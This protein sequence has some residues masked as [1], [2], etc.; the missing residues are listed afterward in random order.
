M[1]RRGW[2]LVGLAAGAAL[3]GPKLLHRALHRARDAQAQANVEAF[4]LPSA[5]LY[6]LTSG[7]LFE[8]LFAQIAADLAATFPRGD[9]LELG[10]GPGRLA[11]RLARLAPEPRLTGVDISPDM[12]E[13]ASRRAA[14]AGLSDRVRFEVGDV[15]ALR[16]ADGRFDA[17]LATFTLHHWPKPAVGLAEIYRVLKPGGEAWIY[18]VPTWL[19]HTSHVGA[20]LA[21][22]AAASPF[23]RGTLDT[24]PWPGPLRLVRRLR[25]RRSEQDTAPAGQ[26]PLDQA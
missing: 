2:L 11:V 14:R 19:W 6:D 26:T 5:R 23:G 24:I 17:V 9:L 7:P 18:E 25:L 1:V 8:S 4:D 21:P 13:R 20:D 22:L 16:F 12:V 15:A 3:L 10:S